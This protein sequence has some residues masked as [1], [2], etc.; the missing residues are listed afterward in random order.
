MTNDLF[1]T[2]LGVIGL[3]AIGVLFSEN[4]RRIDW[5]LVAGG[6]ALQ[7]L[8]ALIFLAVP[9]GDWIFGQ[10]A[11]FFVAV[12]DFTGAGVKFVFGEVL[13]DPRELER[14]FGINKGYVFALHV[15]PTIVFF[16]ALCSMLYYL[17]VLQKVVYGFAWVTKKFMR[18]S[19]AESLAV[20]AEI[21]LGQTES[22]LMIKPYVAKL[23]VPSCSRS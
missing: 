4:R 11:R 5:R 8:L 14:V 10:L 9:G 7:V 19:G 6:L 20:A 2:F 1:R 22:P 21:F 16:S 13:G 23:T 18:L 15:L 12:T 3:L 17:G